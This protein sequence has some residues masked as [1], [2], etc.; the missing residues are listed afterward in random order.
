MAITN[1]KALSTYTLVVLVWKNKG[2]TYKIEYK[3]TTDIDYIELETV[4]SSNTYYIAHLNPNTSYDIRVTDNSDSDVMTRTVTTTDKVTAC[5][6]L[7]IIRK[8]WGYDEAQLNDAIAK[9]EEEALSI[10]ENTITD[11]ER[12]VKNLNIISGMINNYVMY[13]LRKDIVYLNQVGEAQQE[14]D[15]FYGHLNNLN[16][17]GEEYQKKQ[18]GQTWYRFA[19][20]GV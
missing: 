10:I 18:T 8:E 9:R 5:D 19:K 7:E 1:F 16:N 12:S 20:A 15:Q 11:M 14:Y 17:N 13:S 2:S 3:E 6:T 4:Y